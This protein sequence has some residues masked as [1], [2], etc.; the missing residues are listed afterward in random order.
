MYTIIFI[1]E[2]GKNKRHDENSDN[3]NSSKDMGKNE[4]KDELDQ[5]NKTTSKETNDIKE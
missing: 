2:T 4:R 5:N 3:K 1:E